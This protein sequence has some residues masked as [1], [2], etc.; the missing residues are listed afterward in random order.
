MNKTNVAGSSVALL[1]CLGCVASAGSGQGWVTQLPGGLAELAHRTGA[2]GNDVP[3]SAVTAVV[4]GQADYGVLLDV[5]TPIRVVRLEGGFVTPDAQNLN[6]VAVSEVELDDGTILSPGDA[7]MANV[8]VISGMVANN[9]PGEISVNAIDEG[10]HETT[11]IFFGPGA[12]MLAA[13]APSC[14]VTCSENYY[15]CCSGAGGCAKCHCGQGA[16]PGTCDAGGPG[17]TSCSVPWHE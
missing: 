1:L 7:V 4:K 3:Q 2:S 14:S 9:G 13:C 12:A 6:L 16:D 5:F 8:H 17:A 15:A 11:V 10:N